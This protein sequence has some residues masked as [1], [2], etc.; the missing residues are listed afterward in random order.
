MSAIISLVDLV[1][2]TLTLEQFN[3]L[4]TKKD[5][6][7]FADKE[8]LNEKFDGVLTAVDQVMKKLDN[9]EHAF[10]SN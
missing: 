6:D 9:I 2:M 7:N 8:E 1:I 4:V 5:L 10:V 3:K